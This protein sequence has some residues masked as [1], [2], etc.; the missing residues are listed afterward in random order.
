MNIYPKFSIIIPHHNE[1]SLLKRLMITVPD[2]KDIQVIV[3]DDCS[4]TENRRDLEKLSLEYPSYEF[5]F[6]KENQGG[7]AARNFGL[8]KAQGS[9][10][11]FADSDDFFLPSFNDILD[12]VDESFDIVYFNAIS[13]DSLNFSI[14]KRNQRLNSWISKYFKDGN[15]KNLRFLFGEPWCKI[16]KRSVIYTNK[17]QFEETKIHNDTYFSYMIGYYA[18]NIKVIDVCGY[19]IVER[20]SSVSKKVSD[21]RLIMRTK[22]FFQ[23]NLFLKKNNLK[24]VDRLFLSS[25]WEYLKSFQIRKCFQ[26]NQILG[27]SKTN[28]ICITLNIVFQ[29]T[30]NI[31]SNL[32]RK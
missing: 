1:I 7:G 9:F 2:R 27:I 12:S 14:R 10:V 4:N 31:L 30:S 24:I 5:Y 28:F 17:I 11:V 16:I 20:K 19:V 32:L 6:L 22:I 25:Y 3:V 18:E 13:L 21:D 26:M 15:E 29:E 8:S 23:K